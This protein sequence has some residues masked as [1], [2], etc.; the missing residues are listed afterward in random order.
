ML[1][2][3]LASCVSSG[4]INRRV[5]LREYIDHGMKLHQLATVVAEQTDPVTGVTV[6]T[7]KLDGDYDGVT[8]DV[9]RVNFHCP[10]LH[11]NEASAEFAFEPLNPERN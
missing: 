1:V 2:M 6:Y 10:A 5:C 7:V 9:K 4:H 11:S 3:L 8:I